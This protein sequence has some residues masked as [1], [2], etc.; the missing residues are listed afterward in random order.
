MHN[1]NA[2]LSRLYSV[3]VDKGMKLGLQNMLKLDALL[4]FPS[5]QFPA[6]HIAGTNGKG[7]VT[8][9]IGKGLES[10]YPKV[11]VFTSPHIST[12]RERIAI[13]GKLITEQEIEKILPQIFELAEK[14]EIFPTFFEITTLLALKHFAETSVNIAVIE[15]GLGGRLDATNIV[16]SIL[17]VITSIDFDH[18]EFLGN[19]L[20]SIAKEKAGII[21]PGTPVILGPSAQI[22]PVPEPNSSIF[23]QGPFD[24]VE[25][26]NRAIAKKALEYFNISTPAIKKALTTRPACRREKVLFKGKE[27]LLDVSHNPRGLFCLFK[28]LGI[29]KETLRVVFAISQNKDVQACLKILEHAAGNIH[30]VEAPNGRSASPEYLK[31]LLV[32]LGASQEN[33]F[34]HP[35]ISDGLNTALSLAKK[36]NQHVIVCGTFFIMSEA[37][38][39][40]G[41]NDFRDPI[42]MNEAIL[43]KHC[44]IIQ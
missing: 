41:L 21:K 42:D 32:Q 43:K 18:M 6:V 22:V 15:T 27:I 31:P 4:G 8:I 25:Q 23:V 1:Y 7:S 11:G 28:E 17:S 24:D 37:R 36:F 29:A 3:N 14:N 9:K 34:I 30:L 35:S 40:L 12:F 13:N 38:Q 10:R 33:I 26:E 16:H 5:R 2:L 19:T 20:D 44:T 39:F